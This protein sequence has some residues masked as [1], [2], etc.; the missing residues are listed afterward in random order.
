[1]LLLTNYEVN[2]AKYS[3][4]VLKLGTN[5]TSCLNSWKIFP[6]LIEYLIE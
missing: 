1:M 6:K 4:A 3:A 2:T 5:E